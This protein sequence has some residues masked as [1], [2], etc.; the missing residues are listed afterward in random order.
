MKPTIIHISPGGGYD[1]NTPDIE[2]RHYATWATPFSIRMLK[3]SSKYE[4]EVWKPY[5]PK[6]YGNH[7][8]SVR[9]RDGVTFRLF[10]ARKIGPK[11]VS[12]PLLKELGKRIRSRERIL[13]HLQIVHDM[14]AY[15]IALLCRDLPLVA[16]QRGPDCPPRWAFRH[17]K[18]LRY[19]SALLIDRLAIRYYDFIFAASKGEFRYLQEKIGSKNVMH[20]KGGGFDFDKFIPRQKEE[21]RKEL[22]LPINK[23]I[24]VHIGRFTRLKG[25]DTILDAY[26]KLREKHDNIEMIFIGGN[27]NEP[28]YQKIV[29]S[30]A[31]VKGYIA[32]DKVLQH[33][34]ATDVHLLPTRDRKW[35]P[36]GDIPTAVIESLAMNQPVISP[37]LIHFKGH[38]EERKKLGFIAQELDEVVRASEYIFTHPTEF[39]DTRG[40][41][42][43]YYSWERVL[44]SNL[45][46]YDRLFEGYYV[47]ELNTSYT[48]SFDK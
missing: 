5:D 8:V 34:N 28:L 37:M 27:E 46:V 17:E 32:K 7:G 29:E 25:I 1:H 36:F 18:K 12:F 3:F 26:A 11:Y 20:L 15:L 2:S 31:L 22:D 9:E 21:M 41:V 10:P 44:E 48:V 6:D 30:G 38:P 39:E 13:V 23:K 45:E 19:L 33:I 4:I 42:K 16:Q 14:M 47:E 40:I 24:M 43:E 35:I